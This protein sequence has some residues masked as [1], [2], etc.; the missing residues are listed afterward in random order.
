MLTWE[1]EHA[2]AAEMSGIY[3]TWKSESATEDCFRIGANSRCFC[4]CLFKDHNQVFGKKKFQTNCKNCANCKEFKFIPRRPEEV[5]QHWLPR[6]KG[7]DINT[8]RPSC[9][10]CK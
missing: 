10:L 3:M 6:R 9:K 2:Q 5:G 8:W 4:G 1:F 7:F